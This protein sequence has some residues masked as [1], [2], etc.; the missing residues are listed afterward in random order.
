MGALQHNLGTYT[1]LKRTLHREGNGGFE[2]WEFELE[3][4]KYIY[5]SDVRYLHEIDERVIV[6]DFFSEEALGSL[7]PF[8][9]TNSSNYHARKVI[10][11]INELTTRVLPPLRKYRYVALPGGPEWAGV[12]KRLI[13]RL[14]TPVTAE[15]LDIVKKRLN[16]GL[17]V[18]IDSGYCH[19]E[20]GDLI[21]NSDFIKAGLNIKENRQEVK[22]EPVS[23]ID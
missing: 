21:T 13:N 3:D 17:N 22:L 19:C 14:G 2:I 5:Y 8:L 11:C 10:G 6:V 18:E 16:Y 7:N 4:K 12:H 9:P 23:V 1:L 15:I 20:V